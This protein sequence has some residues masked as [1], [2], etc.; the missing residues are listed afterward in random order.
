VN[1]V[2]RSVGNVL[3]NFVERE[4][5]NS[6][7]RADANERRLLFCTPNKGLCAGA[8]ALGFLR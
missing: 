6:H 5:V 8:L 2:K 4:Q 7:R 1:L 3:R